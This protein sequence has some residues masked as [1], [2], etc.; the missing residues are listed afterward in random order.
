[1]V[2]G[3]GWLNL[4]HPRSVFDLVA[5]MEF[6][7]V[8]SAGLPHLPEDF[9]P[10]LAQTAQCAGVA[11]ASFAKR[12]VIHGGPRAALPTQVGP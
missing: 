3:S 1:M 7:I 4:K 9:Q 10:P 11:L 6:G 8:S 2:L 12:F 5:R